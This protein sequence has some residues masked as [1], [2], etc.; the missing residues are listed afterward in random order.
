MTAGLGRKGRIWRE[1]QKPHTVA[2][3]APTAQNS[4]PCFTPCPSTP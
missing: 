4:L 3:A 1:E 2:W